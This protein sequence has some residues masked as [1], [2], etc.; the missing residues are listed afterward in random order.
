MK[1]TVLITTLMAL[2]TL[3]AASVYANHHEGQHESE[4]KQEM[5]AD[6]NNDGKVSY[7]EFKGA[8]EK[9]MEE[10]FKRRDTNS[11]GFIDQAEKDAAKQKWKNHHGKMK[12]GEKCER[13]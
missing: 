6:A 11:D 10:H 4:G 13:K 2:F 9:H 7:D 8:R 1:K 12:D 3:G 5:N